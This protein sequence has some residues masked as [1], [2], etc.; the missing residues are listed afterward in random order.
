ME[1]PDEVEYKLTSIRVQIQDGDLF[2]SCAWNGVP[3]RIGDARALHEWFAG[4]ASAIDDCKTI[5]RTH[6]LRS[7]QRSLETG[8]LRC[9]C[10]LLMCRQA[11]VRPA[12]HT[13]LRPP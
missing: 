3:A 2:T 6:T 13:R 12:Y 9:A 4:I 8:S 1:P 5:R 7:F 10:Y 11:V